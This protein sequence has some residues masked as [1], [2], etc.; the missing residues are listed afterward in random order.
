MIWR[1]FP[2]L[3]PQVDRVVSRYFNALTDE[4][5]IVSFFS[6]DLDSRFTEREAAAVSEWVESGAPI[7]AMRDNP[8][9]HVPLLG[10]GW[11]A[12]LVKVGIRKRWKC[13]WQRILNDSLTYSART[14]KG[15]DQIILTRY[16][17]PWARNMSLQHDS[18]TCHHYPGS[19]GFPTQ[20]RDED[21]NFIAAVGNMRIWVECP[22]LCRRH[23]HWA[24]C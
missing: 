21:Y 16:V 6:R 19:V 9:H 23:K 24:H 10:A 4:C 5:R 1:F 18:Y 15:P 3:D 11:G 14:I 20:R 7:H 13:S 12:S 17:W 2:T 22:Q 8:R